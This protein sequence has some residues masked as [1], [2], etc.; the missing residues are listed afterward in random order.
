MSVCRCKCI[1]Q[2]Q[3]FLVKKNYISFTSDAA[4][5]DQ[6]SISLY[7]SRVGLLLFPKQA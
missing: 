4:E 5:Y 2:P 7:L 1:K 6:Y 3:L